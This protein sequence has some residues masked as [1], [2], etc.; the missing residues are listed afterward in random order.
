LVERGQIEFIKPTWDMTVDCSDMEI[1]CVESVDSARMFL[2]HAFG[3]NV[4]T[5]Y[6]SYAWPFGSLKSAG[7]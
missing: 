2:N 1:D 5:M 4:T 6:S 7:I 3:A